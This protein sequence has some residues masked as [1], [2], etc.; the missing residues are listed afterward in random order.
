MEKIKRIKFR[1]ILVT[2]MVVAAISGAIAGC[3]NSKKKATV[4]KD[5]PEI[6]NIGVQTLITPELISRYE[7]VYEKYLGTKVNLIQFDS[8]ADVN[9]AFSSGSVDIASFGTAPASIGISGNLGYEVF[10]YYDVIG[11]AESLVATKSSK[12][13]DVKGLK[14]KKVATPFASTAHYSLLNAMKLEGVSPSDVELL[15]MQPDAIYAA[16]ERGDIDAAYVWN[17]VLEKLK[18]KDGVVITDSAKLAQKGIVTADVAA[19]R[20]EFAKNYPK[21]VENY[22]KSQ[23]H[24][25]DE[26]KNN[27]DEAIEKI[28]K[29]AGITKEDA[30][31]QVTTFTYPDGNEQV[32]DDYLGNGESKGKLADTLKATADF[33]KEQGS[34]DEVPDLQTFKDNITGEFVEKALK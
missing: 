7:K 6:V 33:L 9:K 34:I 15:D 10:W 22:V 26:Y 20:K 19:V 27:Y 28:A 18:K 2:V 24:A 30:K 29:T 1:K 23:L 5:V 3:G 16:W 4:K 13:T 32:T 11:S 21:I 25:I 31:F 17:P 8:G 14:G 12:I